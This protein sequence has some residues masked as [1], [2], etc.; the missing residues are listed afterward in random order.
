MNPITL[1]NMSIGSA[2]AQEAAFNTVAMAC[3]HTNYTEL[4]K[5]YTSLAGLA[6]D[7]IL[8]G[9]TLYEGMN[10]GF[11]QV[12]NPDKLGALRIQVDAVTATVV[13][14]TSQ[15][16]DGYIFKLKC[17]DKD[18]TLTD[19][20]YT[21]A[22][23]TKTPPSAVNVGVAGACSFEFAGDSDDAKHFLS[24]YT[25]T[26]SGDGTTDANGT[27]TVS[28]DATELGGTVTVDVDEAITAAGSDGTMTCQIDKIYAATML[29]AAHLA[30]FSGS[31]TQLASDNA[32]GTFDIT[33]GT[34]GEA[35]IAY[36]TDNGKISVAPKTLGGSGID[37][38]GKWKSSLSAVELAGYAWYAT[39]ALDRTKAI[40]EGVAD[41]IETATQKHIIGFATAD[42]DVSSKNSTLDTDSLAAYLVDNSYSRSWTLFHTKADGS[43]DEEWIDVG[44]S[45]RNMAGFDPD[46][47]TNYWLYKN[48]V[49]ST[50]DT[51]APDPLTA[52]EIA[53]IVSKGVDF[54]GTVKGLTM[55]LG[56]DTTTGGGGKMANGNSIELQIGADV[57]EDRLE[58]TLLT[59][60]YNI[61][62]NTGKIPFTQVGINAIEGKIRTVIERF[63]ATGFLYRNLDLD[64]VAGYIVKMPALAAISKI[65][66]DNN[67]LTGID[68]KLAYSGAI[69]HIVLDI[70]VA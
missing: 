2:N 14:T 70:A 30:A 35:F 24:G 38:A 37:D 49:G 62:N 9:D 58:S 51:A 32:D 43:T 36:S 69:L 42:T 41:W 23:F 65:D 53:N 21:A 16:Q 22:S 26:Y 66:R 10:S 52:S 34:A 15:I 44:R 45:V 1:I 59:Y 12:P 4:Y 5:E 27:Y 18:G 17:A 63:V 61:S 31:P 6:D 11:L 48:I 47:N 40:Q 54:Y 68:I 60:I 28:G 33:T 8:D 56:G 64:P 3:P 29:V 57:I 50:T 67:L 20:A 55:V 13:N 39:H 25:F 46:V 19:V 7:G